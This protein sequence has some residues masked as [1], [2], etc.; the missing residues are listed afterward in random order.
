MG[1]WLAEGLGL[2]TSLGPLSKYAAGTDVG[3]GLRW[4]RGAAGGGIKATLQ[5]PGALARP[6]S[7]LLSQE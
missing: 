6:C 1:S 3:E 5:S 4:A 7:C 2:R